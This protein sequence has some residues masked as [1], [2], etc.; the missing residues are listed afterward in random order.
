MSRYAFVAILALAAVANAQVCQN[1]YGDANCNTITNL[2]EGARSWMQVQCSKACNFCT[3]TVAVSGCSDLNAG[4]SQWKASCALP[5]TQAWMTVNCPATC[6]ICNTQTGTTSCVN[7]EPAATCNANVALCTTGTY[8]AWMR[9][10]CALACGSCSVST[11]ASTSCT[12]ADT[13]CSGWT[14]YCND[15]NHQV[16]MKANCKLTCAQCG[17]A[18]CTNVETDAS[19][20]SNAALCNDGTW[21]SWM[22][23]NCKKACGCGTPAP[24]AACVDTDNRCSGWSAYCSN[25]LYSD[26]MKTSCKKTC[27]VCST[28]V[29]PGECTWTSVPVKTIAGYAK[30]DNANYGN[31]VQAKAKCVS[32]GDDCCGVSVTNTGTGIFTVRACQNN[33]QASFFAS[34]DTDS[35]VKSCPCEDLE[36]AATCTA[37]VGICNDATWGA[38]MKSNCKK[39]CMQCPNATTAA[40]TPSPTP[41]PTP[42]PTPAPT[43]APTPAPVFGTTYT[44]AANTADARTGSVYLLAD[45]TTT[46][47]QAEMQAAVANYP[48][49]TTAALC[50]TECNKYAACAS[51]QWHVTG[52]FTGLWANRC[53]F[54]NS[55]PTAVGATTT[56][57][58][59]TLGIRQ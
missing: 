33:T 55:A 46:A 11:I 15:P 28:P 19:C 9:T 1:L 38:W 44:T 7:I 5:Q 32:Y 37:Q 52:T 47:T 8:Q 20:T 49:T 36:A 30:D 56:A 21:G 43:A 6:G 26:F 31:L 25:A 2:C 35:Y 24:V 53:V 17:A 3:T 54:A 13:R 57:T 59:I 51:Y 34:P 40:P 12:D 23:T 18:S 39:S 16:W 58:G 48:Q 4:C 45:G 22:M 42:S 27:S 50:G 14:Q 29:T 41:A 10:N